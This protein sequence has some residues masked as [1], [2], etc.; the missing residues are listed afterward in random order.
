MRIDIV[1]TKV[2]PFS[3][4]SD[5][6]KKTAVEK[7]YDINVDHDWWDCIFEDAA[8]VLL[9][10]TEFDIDCASYCK[11]DFVESAEDTAKAILKEHGSSCESFLTA[12]NYLK[13]RSLLVIKYSDGIKTDEVTEDKEYDFDND[14]DEI[15]ADF[16]HSIL[17]DYRIMLQ[18]EYEFLT[19]EKAILET[20]EANAYE[21]TED[22][23]IY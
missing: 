3:E 23:K 11:G 9:E 20:I 21:F 18:K 15:D 19:S 2:F 14:C 1:K 10:L 22:G 7:L 16:I 13:E 6:A 4:L 12:A 8:R 17:E 5:E